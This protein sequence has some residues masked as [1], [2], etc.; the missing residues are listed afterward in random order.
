MIQY[1]EEAKVHL[2]SAL[3]NTVP[4][5]ET[6]ADNHMTYIESVFLSQSIPFQD[7]GFNRSRPMEIRLAALDLYSFNPILR[8]PHAL[9]ADTTQDAEIRISAY[10]KLMTRPASHIKL[11][12]AVL[13]REEVN[14]GTCKQA[15][16]S[17]DLL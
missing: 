11:V 9:F 3:K 14:Q 1:R 13:E 8:F 4:R 16:R 5:D 10:M 7:L 17:N 15:W 12:K 2:L 6:E